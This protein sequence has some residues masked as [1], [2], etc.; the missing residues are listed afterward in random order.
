MRRPID[1]WHLR[2]DSDLQILSTKE[3]GSEE[4][5]TALG[6]RLIFPHDCA[7]WP[8]SVLSDEG[9]AE[10]SALERGVVVGR[11]GGDTRRPPDEAIVTLG[12]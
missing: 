9:C 2:A 11:A 3:A 10:R 6:W 7:R 5:C 1:D 12:S 4:I 8:G